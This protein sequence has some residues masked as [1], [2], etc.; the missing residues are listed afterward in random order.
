[1]P[2]G[3]GDIQQQTAVA[4]QRLAYPKFRGA[5]DSRRIPVEVDRFLPRLEIETQS[6]V[7]RGAGQIDVDRLLHGDQ[8]RQLQHEARSSATS[9]EEQLRV[10]APLG[11]EGAHGLCTCTPVACVREPRVGEGLAFV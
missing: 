6:A 2:T 5:F 9:C 1:M 3:D 7:V 8:G 4:R 10:A 11:S